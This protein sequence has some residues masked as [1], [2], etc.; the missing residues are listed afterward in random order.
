MSQSLP[1]PA[2]GAGP[3]GA[4]D[5]RP[6]NAREDQLL[7]RLLSDP[8][9]LPMGF[10]TWL[11]GYLETSDL[12]L[13]MSSIMGLPTVAASVQ[14]GDSAWHYIGAAGEPGFLNSWVNYGPHGE[15]PSFASSRTAWW[16]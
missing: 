5:N 14:G 8:F 16:W 10:K 4:V 7:Q 9:S 15:L 13:P 6:L 3:S 11:V 2:P 1:L 12:S